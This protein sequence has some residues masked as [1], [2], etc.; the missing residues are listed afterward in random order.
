NAG[1]VTING[2][3]NHPNLKI[4]TTQEYTSKKGKYWLLNITISDI[5]SNFIFDLELPKNSQINYL[6]TPRIARI[7]DS[8]NQMKVVGTGENQRFV[9]IVQYSYSKNNFN[10][11]FYYLIIIPVLGIITYFVLKKI[12]KK[13]KTYNKDALTKRQNEILN[14]VLKNKK[15]TQSMLE[16]KLNMPKSSLSRNIDSLVKKNIIG[17]ERKGM[18]N[19]IFLK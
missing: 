12:T 17:K 11:Y 15:I 14:L 18:T 2:D 9:L 13:K 6:K 7:S 4:D 8:K 3:T 16:K 1:Y 10:N 5:F 19:L